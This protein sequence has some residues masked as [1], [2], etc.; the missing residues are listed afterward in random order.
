MNKTLPSWAQNV[1]CVAG[2]GMVA[3]MLLVWLD[4]GDGIS[5]LR[6]AWDANHWLF[7]VPLAGAGLFM[8]ASTRSQYTRLLAIAAGLVVAGYVLLGVAKSLVSMDLDTAMIFGGAALLLGATKS[9]A[10]RL[11][12]GGLV[13]A[14]FF[15]P[16]ADYSMASMLW[17]GYAAFSIALV[18]WLIPIAGIVGLLAAGNR[19]EGAKLSR[20]A[21]LTVYGAIATVVAVFCVEVFGMGAWLAFGAS[22]VALLV[23]L[24]ARWNP[25]V[26]AAPAQPEHV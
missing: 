22:A 8:A 3:S 20:A 17:H 24:F 16:W 1:L 23:G 2:L 7:L 6:L 11:A 4:F 21:G 9:P 15:A 13:L 14:G 18:L 25:T 19:A 5:G 26:A 12:G 10:M